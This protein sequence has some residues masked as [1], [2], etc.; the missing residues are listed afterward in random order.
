MLYQ[1]PNGK[2]I[3]ITMEQF[4]KMTDEELKG[5]IAFNAGEEVNDPFA[6][7]VLRYG[8]HRSIEDVEDMDDFA[9]VPLEDLTDISDVEKI[10]DDD[11]IDHDNLET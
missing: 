6:L 9:E 2:C 3:E 8:P 7:S 1:L 5:M 11:F 4:L 10:Y